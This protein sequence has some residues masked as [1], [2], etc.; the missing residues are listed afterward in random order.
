MA[1][2]YK[3]DSNEDNPTRLIL[4]A[5]QYGKITSHDS[6]TYLSDRI[7]TDSF[8]F[9]ASQ[10]GF[11]KFDFNIIYQHEIPGEKFSPGSYDFNMGYWNGNMSLSS[12]SSVVSIYSTMPNGELFYMNIDDVLNIKFDAEYT[13]YMFPGTN[14]SGTVFYNLKVANAQKLPELLLSQSG[15]TISAKFEVDLVEFDGTDF[16]T[17]EFVWKVDGVIDDN[18]TSQINASNDLRSSIS[19]EAGYDGKSIQAIY[20]YSVQGSDYSIASDEYNVPSAPE[21]HVEGYP[22]SVLEG[23]SIRVEVTATDSDDDLSNWQYSKPDWLNVTKTTENIVFQGVPQNSDV[24]KVEL[25]VTV[26]DSVG[27]QASD[28]LMFNVLSVNSP[29]YLLSAPPL[30]LDFGVITDTVIQ[31]NGLVSALSTDGHNLRALVTDGDDRYSA[32]ID[33]NTHD[34]GKVSYEYLSKDSSTQI[35]LQNGQPLERVSSGGIISQPFGDYYQSSIQELNGNNIYKNLPQDFVKHSAT[36]NPRFHEI[37]GGFIIIFE[38]VEIESSYN[39]DNEYN[40]SEKI[41]STIASTYLFSNESQSYVNSSVL[42]SDDAREYG[43]AFSEKADVLQLDDRSIIISDLRENSVRFL[44]LDSEGIPLGPDHIHNFRMDVEHGFWT[45][46][47]YIVELTSEITKGFQVFNKFG[48]TVSELYEGNWEALTSDGESIYLSSIEEG[49][50]KIRQLN[51]IEFLEIESVSEPLQFS[52]IAGGI[53]STVDHDAGYDYKFFVSDVDVDDTLTLSAEKK[54]D[55]LNFEPTTGVL[56]GTGMVYSFLSDELR[57]EAVGDHDITLRATDAAGAFTEQH[58]TI[59]VYNDGNDLLEGGEGNDVLHGGTGDDDILGKKGDDT[60]SG[61]NGSDIL[62]GGEGDDTLDGGAGDDTL[63]GGRGNDTVRGGAGDDTIV[64]VGGSDTFDGGEGSDTLLEDN[65]G[66]EEFS[67]DLYFDLSTGKHGVV[68]KETGIDEVISI[69]NYTIEEA[70][71]VTLTGDGNSNRFTANVGADVLY[72]FGGDDT[73]SGGAGSDILDGGEGDDT[74]ILVSSDT[75]SARYLAQNASSTLQIGTEERINLNGKTRFGDVMDGG[76]DTD[77]VELTDSSDAFFLHDSFSGFHS[78]LE[79]V[80]DLNGKSGTARIENIENINSGGGDDIIDLT[81]SD[82]SLSGQNITVEGGEGNDTLWGSDADEILKGGNG[83]DVLFGGA[84]T[85]QLSGGNGTDEFQFTRTSISDTVADYNFSD[86][87]ILKFFYEAGGV[88]AN[89]N[90]SVL[91][92]D[93]RWGDNTLDLGALEVTS[94]NDLSIFVQEIGSGVATK[95]EYIPELGEE[96]LR[97]DIYPALYEQDYYSELVNDLRL[98]ELNDFADEI[99]LDLIFLGELSDVA[100]ATGVQANSNG[101]TISAGGNYNDTYNTIE[102]RADISN[103]TIDGVNANPASFQVLLEETSVPSGKVGGAFNSITISANSTDYLSLKHSVSGLSIVYDNAS[104]NTIN[105]LRLDGIFE[106]D[107]NKVMPVFSDLLSFDFTDPIALLGSEVF[108][109]TS[110]NMDSLFTLSGFSVLQDNVADPYVQIS[111]TDTSIEVAYKD[112]DLVGE[113]EVSDT[114]QPNQ[115]AT[116]TALQNLLSDNTLDLTELSSLFE[117]SGS[118]SLSVSHDNV[119]KVLE[120]TIQD[121]GSLL[122]S[123]DQDV[124]EEFFFGARG[125]DSFAIDRDGLGVV[126][127]KDRSLEDAQIIELLETLGLKEKQI[128]GT[129]I[130]GAGAVEGVNVFLDRNNNFALDYDEESSVTDVSGSFNIYLDNPDVEGVSLIAS[131]LGFEFYASQFP[132]MTLEAPITSTV[133]SPLTTLMERSDKTVDEIFDHLNISSDIDVFTFN[134]LASDVEINASTEVTEGMQSIETA[135]GLA[136][137]T[138]QAMGIP[139]IPDYSMVE[140]I[141][142]SDN[143]LG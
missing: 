95:F 17:G 36:I 16:E 24:G 9:T 105:E 123:L 57:N 134:P 51:F 89:W 131:P 41:S 115:D 45:N 106:N 107:L 83:N 125:N 140:D 97:L 1:Y 44:L 10:S 114:W 43:S 102:I 11:Y 70:F 143:I 126:V 76:A 63:T 137:I 122:S 79:L 99:D 26:A 66:L 142:F 40:L 129:V 139:F 69:E 67:V 98:A 34:I 141:L 71:N 110:A 77:S 27:N 29:P 56:S 50:L 68:G 35:V 132:A 25:D 19:I 12:G 65:T 60:L 5:F 49:S 61:G 74:I 118:L 39:W 64:A 54:P 46:D 138:S 103:F 32:Q 59:R 82:Y 72:G 37:D 7:D 136:T 28:S 108:L 86:G 112:W 18:F 104:S 52:S 15:D 92:G 55:W 2:E 14:T 23:E 85:N 120:G 73:L 128:E 4:G 21:I 130:S 22:T 58:F 81:S 84:G 20:K 3:Q 93:L 42:L 8:E 53:F 48:E 47:L 33:L 109:Q 80:N 135:V 31:R 111:A 87:D 90:F 75:F 30:Q 78:S 121:Y 38:A 101:F 62:D 133:I 100:V 116:L 124:Q 6:F 117:G 96:V 91:N 119:G 13:S 113:I 127:F 94:L 88:E